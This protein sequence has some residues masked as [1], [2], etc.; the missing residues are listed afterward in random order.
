MGF[1]MELS[2]LVAREQPGPT[3]ITLCMI[4]SPGGNGGDAT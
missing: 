4:H 1:V 2:P 3:A